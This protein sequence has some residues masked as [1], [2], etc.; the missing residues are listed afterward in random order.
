MIHQKLIGFALETNNEL[1]NA[2]AKLQKKNLDFVVLNS[3]QDKGAGFQNDTN[4][5]SFVFQ[6]E[7][8]TFGLKPKSDPGSIATPVSFSITSHN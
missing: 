4:K 8:K 3:L 2:K 7:V 5:V 6:D 1:E